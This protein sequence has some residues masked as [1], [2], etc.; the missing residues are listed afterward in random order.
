MKQ[1]QQY[2]EKWKRDRDL[3]VFVSALGS[4]GVTL[5]FALYNGWLGLRHG[6]LWHGSICVYYI[7]LTA[8]RAML[9]AAEPRA[10]KKPEP[11]RFRE[12]RCAFA[13]ALLLLLNVSLVVPAALMVRLQKP[14]ELSLIPAIA[15]AAHTTYKVI[16][17]SVH[18][19]RSRKSANSLVR[20]LRSIGFIDALVSILTLQNT[21]IMV[22]SAGGDGGMRTLTALTS[23]AVLLV[24]LALALAALL[25]SLRRL[26][27]SEIKEEEESK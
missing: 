7:I 19:K 9:T 25:R 20:L 6:S 5:L 16:M 1:L 18:L 2:I 21:L 15:M 12:R 13:S 4:T 26:R 17:A 11:E 8:L 23:G 10:G 24:N 3:R 14:V 27:G 22:N